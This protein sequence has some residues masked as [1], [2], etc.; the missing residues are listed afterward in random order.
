MASNSDPF[1]RLNLEEKVLRDL[2]RG[3]LPHVV[4]G[5]LALLPL[6]QGQITI[7]DA[8]LVTILARYSWYTHFSNMYKSPGRT[9]KLY[10][11]RSRLVGK[12]AKGKT[13]T[14]RIYMHRDLVGAE[15]GEI[16]SHINDS[17][18][19]NRTANLKRTTQAEN[20]G[21]ADGPVEEVVWA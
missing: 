3:H 20:M 4:I 17:S 13:I 11:A 8:E 16:V 19:D 9:P 12:T 10:A 1:Q 7:V 2:L 21:M 5:G 18:L 15:K 6:T 14:Q